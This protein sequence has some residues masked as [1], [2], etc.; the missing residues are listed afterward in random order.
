MDL[1]FLA[2][3]IQYQDLFFQLILYSKQ[4]MAFTIQSQYYPKQSLGSSGLG[5]KILTQE[6]MNSIGQ[7]ETRT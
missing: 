7:R 2:V 1:V 5:E 6:N 3:F 4:S